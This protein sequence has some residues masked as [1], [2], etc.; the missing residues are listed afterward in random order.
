MSIHSGFLSGKKIY[1]KPR[2]V[3]EF[4]KDFGIDPKENDQYP[5]KVLAPEKQE[6]LLKTI[7]FKRFLK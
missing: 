6:D 3:A 5:D 7:D 2:T 4:N 1:E